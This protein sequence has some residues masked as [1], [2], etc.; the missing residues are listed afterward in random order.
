MRV[1]VDSSSLTD[2]RFKLLGKALGMN[3]FEAR[4]RCLY[5]WNECYERASERLTM[6]EVDALAEVDGFARAMISVGLA[7]FIESVVTVAGVEQRIE[8]I[9]SR[10]KSALKGGKRTREAW[11]RRKSADLTEGHMACQEAYHAESH[12]AQHAESP[13]APALAPAPALSQIPECGVSPHDALPGLEIQT[14]R[15]PDPAREAAQSWLDWFNQRFA[16]RF[17]LTQETV[18]QVRA[19]LA[20]GYLEKPDMRGV[21]LFLRDEWQS[22]PEMQRYLKPMSILVAEKFGE[23]LDEARERYP[24]WWEKDAQDGQ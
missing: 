24:H 17:T 15:K 11:A 5:V 8:W 21:A 23:R 16:R 3:H 10:R 13:L 14:V 19:L 18:K 6:D 7:S 12:K 2:P 1:N 9:R 20:R 22:K 4:G